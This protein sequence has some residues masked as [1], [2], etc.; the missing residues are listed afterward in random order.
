[1]ASLGA[2]LRLFGAGWTL[3]RNDALLPRELDA[4]YSPA[5]RV[6][7]N[8]LRIFASRRTG[9]PG[10]RLA[11]SLEG[12]GPVAIKLGQLLSTRGDIFGRQFAEDMGRLKDKLAPFPMVQARAVIAQEL[13]QPV[14]AIFASLGEPVAAASLAQAHPA[15]LMDGR[16][17]A[18]KVL[19]PGIE[20]RVAADSAV[21]ALAA[22]LVERWATP[23]RRLEPVKL[24][25]TVIRAT[26]LELDLRL[27]AAGADE[28]AEV[29][30]KD[31]YMSAPKVLWEGVGKRVLTMAWADG[32]ALSDEAALSQPGL[33]RKALAD[34]LTRAFLAQALDHGVFH[35]D[36]HEGNLFAAAPAKLQAV[37]FGI[38]GRLGAVERRYLAE[39]LWGFLQR[40][41]PRVAQV[42]FDAGYVPRR[43]SVAAFAQALRAVGE[44]VFGQRA[45]AVAMSRVLTQLF[46]ITALYDMHL[47]PELVLLQK[48]MMTVEG[49]ARRIDPLHDIWGA[50]E[51]VVRR[52]IARELSPVSRVKQLAGEA[53]SAIRNIARLAQ[54]AEAVVVEPP[55]SSALLWFALG[56]L[57]AGVAF[58]AG[59][60]FG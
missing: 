19:R 55:R 14:E 8:T 38:I 12:L 46:E 24:A 57:A 17:V 13:G 41:Y 43:H 33:D 21:L 42:H 18:V 11:R 2:Y 15:T 30:A 59:V 28:L 53:E 47:R 39:I 22:K 29:M 27:E 4:F 52:W 9:R 40:D 3:V 31:G 51:P 49:V 60:L 54:P 45:N 10:E 26:E 7:A 48:T 58:L 36:L 5:V 20:R 1:M 37:D 44:P 34:N 16:A 23:I 35:A 25:D 32:M 50:S 56:A 6:G